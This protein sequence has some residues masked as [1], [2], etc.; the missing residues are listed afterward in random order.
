MRDNNPYYGKIHSLAIF[1]IIS[2]HMFS[3]NILK[4]FRG[5]KCEFFIRNIKVAFLK[6][7]ELLFVHLCVYYLNF[8]L[9]RG[10]NI[11]FKEGKVGIFIFR[12][13]FNL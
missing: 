3:F 11:V 9:D 13:R 4:R 5:V 2:H 6:G 10:Y 12:R 7:P 8:F 1:F